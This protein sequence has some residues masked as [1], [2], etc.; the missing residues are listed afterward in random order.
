MSPAKSSLT[1]SSHQQTCG[2][3]RTVWMSWIQSSR[4]PDAS[5]CSDESAMTR[6]LYL[7]PD[8]VQAPHRLPRANRQ[9]IRAG[10]SNKEWCY[11]QAINDSEAEILQ[12]ECSCR[13][14]YALLS[15]HSLPQQVPVLGR[16]SCFYFPL[17]WDNSAFF[18][19]AHSFL[20]F[21]SGGVDKFVRRQHS[22]HLSSFYC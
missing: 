3:T 9:S 4:L 1:Y 6:L 21:V 13:A 10:N 20:C 17:S 5:L 14:I 8:Y 22:D 2:W 7:A 11:R 12:F 15:T 18:F 16:Q 19:A